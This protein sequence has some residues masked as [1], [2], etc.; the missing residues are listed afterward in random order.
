[1]KVS[2]TYLTQVGRQNLLNFLISQLENDKLK[3]G[4]ITVAAR[5]FKLSKATV[6]RLW[7][8]WEDTHDVSPNQQWSAGKVRKKSGRPIKYDREALIE[9]IKAIPPGKRGTVRLLEGLSFLFVAF[10]CFLCAKSEMGVDY[11]VRTT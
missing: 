2:R 11:V 8:K 3:R 5:R 6:S 10:S 7:K 9:S 1:M 4:S